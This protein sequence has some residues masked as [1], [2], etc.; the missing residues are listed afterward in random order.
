M[1]RKPHLYWATFAI[2]ENDKWEI[3][4]QKRCNTGYY[5]G[6]YSLPSGHID[7]GEFASESIIHEMEEELGIIVDP[8]KNS[9]IHV[10]H[11]LD[12]DRQ[13]FDM[14]YLIDTREWEIINNE[15]DKCS[16]LLR[17]IPDEL[18]EYITPPALRFIQSYIKN[19]KV[20][21]FSEADTRENQSLGS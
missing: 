20:L 14:C 21:V 10:L 6:W 12:H 2:I 4:L 3:L 19:W 5:D 11:R 15:L 7:D 18:P 1:S 13:Y 16:E 9:L 8:N 17:C